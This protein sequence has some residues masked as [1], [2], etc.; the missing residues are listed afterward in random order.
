MGKVLIVK[1]SDF[2]DNSIEVQDFGRGCPVDWNPV[3]KKYNWELVF[4]EL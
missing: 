2:E 4:C 3:E 1:D